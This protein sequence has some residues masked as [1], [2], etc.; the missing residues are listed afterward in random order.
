MSSRRED[1]DDQVDRWLQN[2]ER[3]AK[4]EIRPSM[5]EQ[6][7][8][9]AARTRS[10]PSTPQKLALAV[11]AGL[12]IFLGAV[13]IA[14]RN[15]TPDPKQSIAN[16]EPELDFQQQKTETL[17][18]LDA[19]EFET[20]RLQQKLML[21]ELQTKIDQELASI[22]SLRRDHEHRVKLD[23]IILESL[24]APDNSTEP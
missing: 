21:V 18:G 1:P 6:L 13:W 15:P 23:R 22:R 24:N 2:W 16:A 11:T 14:N 17:E 9:R 5:R 7:I 20:K 8:R 12:A 10:Y 19:L 3:N 4:G